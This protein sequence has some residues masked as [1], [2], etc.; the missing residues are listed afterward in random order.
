MSRLPVHSRRR[1]AW[2]YTPILVTSMAAYF[3][4]YTQTITLNGLGLLTMLIAFAALVAITK[5]STPWTS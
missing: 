2:I 5:E 1:I 3:Y 4:S